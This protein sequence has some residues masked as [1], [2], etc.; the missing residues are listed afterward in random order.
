MVRR[1]ELEVHVDIL[2]VLAR[3]GPLKRTHIMYEANV[4]SSVLKQY[5]DLLTQ[6]NLVEEQ[7][8]HKKGVVYAIT[9]RG[10]AVLKYFMEVDRALQMRARAPA[11]MAKCHICGRNIDLERVDEYFKCLDCGQITCDACGDGSECN[12][13]IADEAFIA[14]S[15]HLERGF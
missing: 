9:E 3:H 12:L 10:L 8:L 6:H 5:L 1:S 2:K 4:N 15:L 14:D 11:N 7:T 13:C